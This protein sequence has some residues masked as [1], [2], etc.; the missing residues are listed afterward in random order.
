VDGAGAAENGLMDWPQCIRQWHTDR[1]LHTEWCPHRPRS[2]NGLPG[3][4]G[5]QRM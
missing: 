4:S 5:E 3:K 2:I 1:H